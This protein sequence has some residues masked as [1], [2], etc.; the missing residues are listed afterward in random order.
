MKLIE[1]VPDASSKSVYLSWS[2][3]PEGVTGFYIYLYDRKGPGDPQKD[4]PESA[5]LI[6]T[7]SDAFYTDYK[8]FDSSILRRDY[9]YLIRAMDTRGSV[10]DSLSVQPMKSESKLIRQR[11]NA[12]NY[13]AQ[14]F[15]RN[16][17]WAE[18]LYILRYRKTGK[19]CF[20]YIPDFGKAGN[21]ACE[22]CYG[23]GYEGGF[24]TPIPTK[25]LPI[26][27]QRSNK[28]NYQ[29]EPLVSDQRTITVPR[30]P[31]IYEKDLL[32]SDSMGLLAVTSTSFRA[33]QSEPTPTIM[34]T[35]SAL[36]KEHPAYKFDF[37]RVRTSIDKIE[38]GNPP[39]T[40]KVTGRGLMPVTGTFSLIIKGLS[41]SPERVVLG[42]KE[43]Y[44]VT[45][46]S[47]LFKSSKIL[48][49]GNS[50][51]YSLIMNNQM[52]EGTSF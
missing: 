19:K 29:P 34:V 50:F 7:T 27:H 33:V 6:G 12:A 31:A 26:S 14:L 35:T 42:M 9:M 16:F 37:D 3:F 48:G 10:V 51:V 45:E 32:Y 43:L 21:V 4:V 20:C 8:Y 2:D 18:V 13:A 28:G 1:C 39:G 17:N 23:G 47:M 40:V 25:I 44:E 52:I 22:V 11:L 41:E 36:G 46:T 24:Y 49:L 30:F 15:F 5:E 38:C